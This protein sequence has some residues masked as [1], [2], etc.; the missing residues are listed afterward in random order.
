MIKKVIINFINDVWDVADAFLER[1][2]EQ[3]HKGHLVR[4]TILGIAAYLQTYALFWCFEYA[5]TSPHEPMAI[6]AVVGAV[7]APV[8]TLFGAAIKFYND[9]RKQSSEVPKE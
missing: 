2:Y 4:R 9:G 1:V 5:T 6:A 8:S 7:M 3:L